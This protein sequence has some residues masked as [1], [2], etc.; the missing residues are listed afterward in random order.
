MVHSDVLYFFE[1]RQ[2]PKRREDWGKLLPP[3]ACI[4]DKVIYNF[5]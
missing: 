1:R 3:L 2:G 5:K 4:C